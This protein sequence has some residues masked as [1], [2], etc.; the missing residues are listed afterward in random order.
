VDGVQWREI[1]LA[2][3]EAVAELAGL[4]AAADGARRGDPGLAFFLGMPDGLG[5]GAFAGERLVAAVLLRT[6]FAPA[7]EGHVH[8]AY[9]GRGLGAAALDWALARAPA[10]VDVRTA[11]LTPA[12][13]RLFESR[14]LHLAA[15][16]ERLWRPL[17]EP[18]ETV[19][20][21]PGITIAEWDDVDGYDM[22]AESFAELP[23][24]RFADAEEPDRAFEDWVQWTGY[25][26]IDAEHSLLARDE[27]GDPVGFVSC[28]EHGPIQIGVLPD[29]RRQGLGRALLTAAM[30][31]VTARPD[32]D[33][34]AE[35]TVNAG[36]TA[37]VGLFRRCGFLVDSREGHFTAR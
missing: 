28:W 3:R 35:L 13:Q 16:L 1:R 17:G 25:S 5:V 32:H 29:R 4:G 33:E 6:R 23:A 36:N 27:Q 2:D 15:A 21:P 10:K 37:A 22:Y 20:A 14:G 19:P 7:I 11:A 26:E 34:P 30:A 8:P 31:R 9:R 12:A 24:N 18:V